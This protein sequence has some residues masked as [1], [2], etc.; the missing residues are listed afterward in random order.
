MHFWEDLFLVLT[1]VFAFLALG[2]FLGCALFSFT[3]F[4][5]QKS[6]N[7]WLRANIQLI[8]AGLIDAVLTLAALFCYRQYKRYL[9]NLK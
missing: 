7:S 3:E 6:F 4:A 8:P 5:G 9:K 1:V 2:I